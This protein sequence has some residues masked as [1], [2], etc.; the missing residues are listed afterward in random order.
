[1]RES[2]GHPDSRFYVS[3]QLQERGI[4]RVP[5]SVSENGHFASSSAIVR[6][7]R[8][9]Q[10]R[11]AVLVCSSGL[12]PAPPCLW[13]FFSKSSIL[14]GIARSGPLQKFGKCEQNSSE[15]LF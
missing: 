15:P 2:R 9:E 7:L 12:V 5:G 13:S 1:M 14:S 11:S 4:G 3:G 10:F 6:L 8:R